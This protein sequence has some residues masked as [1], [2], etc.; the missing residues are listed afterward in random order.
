[1]TPDM[2]EV[3]VHPTGPR[4]DVA[5]YVDRFLTQENATLPRI[6]IR[7][8]E[9]A[10]I[11]EVEL[12]RPMLD[13]GCGDGTF[14]QTL[15]DEPIDV[16]VDNSRPQMIRAQQLHGYRN[17]V[18]ASGYALPLLDGSFG[19]VFSNSTLEHIPRTWEVIK[20][21]ARVL[22]PGGVCVI[23]VPSEHFS[24]YL[25]G[26]QVLRKVGFAAGA[27]GY[28][29]FFNRVCRHQ[30][31]E[32]AETWLGWLRD[33]GLKIDDW[34]YYYSRRDTVMLELAHYLTA[35]SVVTR[36]AFGRWVLWPGKAKYLPYRQALTPF[37]SPG[38]TAEGAFIFIRASK[39]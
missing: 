12:P 33:A 34:R 20:E 39:P 26:S 27:R 15:F 18:E 29:R 23:T 7:S 30:H 17:L 38:P 32:P 9:C 19:S 16:G 24:R 11:S 13:I 14:A 25:A 1:M 8:A 21:A 10:L 5:N 3:S 6:L 36:A 37:S 35:P 31:I 4:P 2:K 28:E 22:R